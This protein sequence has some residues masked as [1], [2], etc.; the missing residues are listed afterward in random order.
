MRTAFRQK[1]KHH[2]RCSLLTTRSSLNI[3]QD[4]MAHTLD[5]STRAYT[6]LESGVNGCNLMTFFIFLRFCCPD[7]EALFSEL[8]TLVDG[9]DKD[10]Q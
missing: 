2:I 4:E 7:R 10:S 8:F 9:L 1:L 3:S 5:M 6:K